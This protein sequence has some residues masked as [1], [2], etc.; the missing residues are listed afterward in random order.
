MNMIFFLTG[1]DEHGQK[2]ETAAKNNGVILKNLWIMFLKIL[3]IY[4][5]AP[6]FQMIHYK[7]VKKNTSNHVKKFGKLLSNGNI[8]R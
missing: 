5:I 4:L 1:T 6:D 8:Y 3:K 7:N 2:V